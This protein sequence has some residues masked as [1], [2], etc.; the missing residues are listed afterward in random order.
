VADGGGKACYGLRSLTFS[1]WRGLWRVLIYQVGK[2]GEINS[3]LGKAL[4]VLGHAE[5]LEPISDLLH[6]GSA[7][8]GLSGLT[9]PH[10]RAYQ[11][12]STSKM[13]SSG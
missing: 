10:G 4:G 9:H 11:D 1:R 2:D 7:P 5:L 6:R 13:R 8:W 3:I 12:C